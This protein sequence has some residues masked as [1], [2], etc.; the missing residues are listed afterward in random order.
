MQLKN[1]PSTPVHDVFFQTREND[2]ILAT[3]GRGLWILDDAT[4]IQRFEPAAKAEVKLYPVRAGLRFPM[5]FTRYGLGD[6]VY[7][8]KNPPNGA[9]ISYMLP[10]DMGPAEGA[11]AKPGP[12]R[13]KLEILDGAKV[14]REIQKPPMGKGVN[15]AAWDLKFEGPKPRKEGDDTS[16]G[17]FAPSLDG[18]AALPGLYTVRLTADGKS[19]ETPVEVRIDP[20]V[21]VSIDALRAQH[22]LAARLGG[23]ITEANLLLRGLDGIKVQL[24]E[25]KKSLEA[26]GRT[27]SKDAQKAL[28]EY[29]AAHEKVFDRVGLKDNIPYYS[30]PPRVPGRLLDLMS[31]LDDGYAAPTAGQREYASKLQGRLEDAKG[32]YRTLL[33][34]PFAAMN[35]AFTKESL[36]ALVRP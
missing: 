2:L 35:A 4:P 27:L 6:K 16:G 19:M 12:A 13:V 17:D 29:S 20:L 9:L 1:L 18:P 7:K 3:H 22:E 28:D 33:E 31:V 34:G 26:L 11:A 8:A 21:K 25:R 32:A 23:L 5:R 24:D 14:I 36:P 10:E 15:R 30:E